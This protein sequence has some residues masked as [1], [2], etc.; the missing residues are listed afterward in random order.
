[1][2]SSPVFAERGGS[3]P[4]GTLRSISPTMAAT[5]ADAAGRILYARTCSVLCIER[6]DL[7]MEG[8]GNLASMMDRH[9]QS[10]TLESPACARYRHGSWY[11]LPLS[12]LRPPPAPDP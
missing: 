5:S 1:M 11:V 2:C 6:V 12:V 4:L 3:S 8:A 10:T 9:E 7:G